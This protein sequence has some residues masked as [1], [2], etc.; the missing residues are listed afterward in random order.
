MQRI[1]GTMIASYYACKRELWYMA[2]Q[3]TPD[4][5]NPFLDLGRLVEEE[6]YQEEKKKFLIG[7]VLIDIVRS[8]E[9]KLIVGEIKKSSRSK[10]SGIMQLY[11]YLWYLKERGVKARGEVLFPRE[12]RKIP[13]VLNRAIEEEL[14]RAMREIELII[15]Q[16]VPPRREK[17]PL[18]TPCAFRDFCFA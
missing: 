18:C 14:K 9:G 17:I 8:E 7:D 2:H 12:K 3:I 6:S 4:Q 10:R 16:E 1:N 13:L 11:F 5:D 15:A